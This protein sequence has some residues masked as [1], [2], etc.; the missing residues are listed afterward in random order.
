MSSL[1]RSATVGSPGLYIPVHKRTS[2]SSSRAT[3]PSSPGF[4][5]ISGDAYARIYTP[6]FLLSLRPNADDGV[7]EKM[8]EACPEVVMNRRTR[9]NLEFSQHQREGSERKVHQSSSPRATISASFSVPIAALVAPHAIPHKSRP[10]GRVSGQK[11][12][13]FESRFNLNDR[14]SHVP[15]PLQRLSII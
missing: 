2:S 3:S 10:S 8:R 7:R 9:K 4:P 15:I 14:W 13:S 1:P 12:Q 6:E 5:S 11:D